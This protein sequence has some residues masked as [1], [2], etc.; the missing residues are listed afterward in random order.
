MKSKSKQ[1]VS[2]ILAILLEFS[3]LLGIILFQ[4]SVLMLLPLPIRAI[5]MIVL[6]WMLLIVPFVFMKKYKINMSDIGFTKTQISFQIFTGILF[7]VV[8][9]LIFTILPILAGYREIVG[10][11]SYTETWQFC[12]QFVYMIL[13]VAL[14][15]EV[16]YRG[17]LFDRIF[18]LS[19]SKWT[20]IIISSCVFGLSHIFGG[21]IVQVIT[22]FMLGILFCL[23]R[24]NIKNCT[25]LSLVIMHGIYNSLITL[26]VVL[27]P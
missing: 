21:N 17:F 18:K 5:L 2:L 9:S 23:C 7:G 8:M 27:L 6:Q 12:Y 22:T 20:T 24:E 14:V 3:V 11:S 16:F 26:F 4:N 15:E 10:S 25:T 13:G 1:I 19:Q